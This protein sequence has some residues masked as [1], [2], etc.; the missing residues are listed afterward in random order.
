MSSSR[1]GVAQGSPRALGAGRWAWWLVRLAARPA[2]SEMFAWLPVQDKLCREQRLL[3]RDAQ[4][5]LEAISRF[6]DCQ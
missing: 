1:G 3:A 4:R 6:R 2:G 5:I